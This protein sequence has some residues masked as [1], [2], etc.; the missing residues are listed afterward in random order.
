[1]KHII[2]KAERHVRDLL[3]NKLGPG[4]HF[5]SIDHT[6]EAVQAAAEIGRHSGLSEEQLEPVLLA[7][8]FH[9]T[10]HVVQYNGHEEKSAG[11]A[12]AFLQNE[13]YPEEKT[14]EVERIIMATRMGHEPVDLPEQIMRDADLLHLGRKKAL[15]KGA[16]LRR[17][18]AEVLNRH[19]TDR[20]WL[21][22][23]KQFYTKARFY[24][25]YA[26]EQYNAG[27]KK[28]LAKIEKRL[29]TEKST[30]AGGKE[31]LKQTTA[32]DAAEKK[33]QPQRGVETVFRTTSRNHLRLSA[34]ADNKANTLISISAIIISIVLSFLIN[35]LD[36]MPGLMIP[37]ISLLITCV[38]TI[39]F[40][41]LSTKPK[42]TE[43]TISR[44]D[45]RNRKGNLLFFGNFYRM[46]LED[47]LWGM[48]ELMHDPDYLYNN[49]TRDIYY[50]G[51]VL[52]KKYR[53]LGIAYSVFMWGLII[54]VVS[55]IVTYYGFRP[56]L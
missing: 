1:M 5:H 33:K 16:L 43:N 49:L 52:A 56:E 15:K 28:N 54:S 31:K 51:L 22:L 48:Q 7:A 13:K 19:F 30:T 2:E 3:N 12:R 47:Y 46:K 37:T 11:I 8:W 26:R 39:I 55:F 50:L 38:V 41:T 42:V 20:E 53:F 18:K 9:D 10:G 24:T 34:I 32:V 45:I 27:I 4:Y 36:V 35:T 17:E 14:A 25:D 23:D 21:E 29:D 40:A 44:E 6:V